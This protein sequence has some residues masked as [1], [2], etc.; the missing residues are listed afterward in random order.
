MVGLGCRAALA[1]LPATSLG[2]GE[3][4][5]V[6]KAER[7]PVNCPGLLLMINIIKQ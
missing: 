7:K 1:N 6:R 3:E 4:R 2:N 5:K